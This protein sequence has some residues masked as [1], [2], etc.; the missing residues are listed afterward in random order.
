MSAILERGLDSLR[1]AQA[2]AADRHLPEPAIAPC[3]ALPLLTDEQ[4]AAMDDTGL[5]SAAKTEA[6]QD[7]VALGFDDT[8]AGELAEIHLAADAILLKARL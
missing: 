7:F 6:M 8:A 2:D 5:F 4:C 1:R 3:A